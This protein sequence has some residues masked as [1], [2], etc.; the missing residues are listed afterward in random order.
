[1]ALYETQILQLSENQA[2]AA[3]L[4]YRSDAGD[5]SDVMRAHVN[6][7]DTR[8]KHIGLQIERAQSY[9]VLANLGGLAR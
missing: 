5:F 8:L 4:A 3:L 7:L 6:N 2:E 1:M 9:A